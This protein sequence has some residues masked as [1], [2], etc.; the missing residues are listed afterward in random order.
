MTEAAEW[1]L[2]GAPVTGSVCSWEAG[3]GLQPGGCSAGKATVTRHSPVAAL[4]VGG[5]ELLPS[6][7]GGPTHS[8]DQMESL[9]QYPL[10]RAFLGHPL[11][12]S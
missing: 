9:S 8:G 12:Q 4:G 7:R 2:Q 3:V 10:L 5:S 6:Q 1:V 11:P